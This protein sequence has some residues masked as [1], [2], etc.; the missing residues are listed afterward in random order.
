MDVNRRRDLPLARR[1]IARVK[2]ISRSRPRWQIQE[3]VEFCPK[4]SR[5]DRSLGTYYNGAKNLRNFLQLS[6]A[7]SRGMDNAGKGRR[8]LKA[9][10]RAITC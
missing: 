5:E 10:T 3:Q 6:Q 8:V 4:K 9:A 1:A 7:V 2:S